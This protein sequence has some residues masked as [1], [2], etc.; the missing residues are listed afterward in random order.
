[1]SVPPPSVASP[2]TRIGDEPAPA[3]VAPLNIRTPWRAVTMPVK[4]FAPDRA[5]VP[6]PSFERPRTAPASLMTPLLTRL[7]KTLAFQFCEL[8]STVSAERVVSSELCVAERVMPR[9]SPELPKV[10]E[11]PPPAMV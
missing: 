5:T 1:M 8:A 4:V 2:P 10:R 7:L 11:F 6:A 9:G 3:A